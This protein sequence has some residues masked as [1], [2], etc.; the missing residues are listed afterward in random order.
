E[1]WKKPISLEIL[2]ATSK[3]TLIDHLQIIYT[4]IGENS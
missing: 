1:I 4:E 2:N 3:N